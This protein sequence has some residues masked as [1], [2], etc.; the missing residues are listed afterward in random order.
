MKVTDVKTFFVDPGSNKNWLFVRIETNEGISGWGECYTIWDRDRSIEAYINHIKRY[1]IGRS[2]FNIKHFTQVMYDDYAARRG[3]MDYYSAMSGIEQALWDI[4][5]KRLNVPVYNLLGGACRDKIRVYA[6]YWYDSASTPEEFAEKAIETVQSGFTALK[7][8]PFPGPWRS[9]ISKQ[10]E[11]AS[12]EV[13]RAVREAVGPNIDL[14]I[15][16]HRRLSPLHAVR[17]AKMIEEFDIFWYEE[18]VVS[19]N[20][21]AL[22]EVRGKI[23]LPVVTGETLYT[24]SAF[25]QV[26][27]KRAADIIN[28]DVCNCGGILELKE[29]AA[30][31]EPY[32]V[33]VSPHNFNSTTI[34]LAATL[35]ISACIPNFLI[36]E[37][38]V[39]FKAR[40]DEIA[41]NPLKVENGYIR[42]P[43]G[44]GLGL[45]LNEE[46]MARYPYREFTKRDIRQYYEEGP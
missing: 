46:A 4:I 43:Q 36:T 25:R 27:E 21:E 35:N 40:G 3:T 29:I 23:N 22:A 7:F 14:L 39:N 5:G 31:A 34:G 6:N 17:V 8:D 10:D 42:I 12:V 30:M 26:F 13:V 37:Y 15:E 2:P 44:P 16:V 20:I 45:V 33:V 19:D 1:L 24:K 32:H 41:V 28:P 11:K 38:F 18:P 9:Y